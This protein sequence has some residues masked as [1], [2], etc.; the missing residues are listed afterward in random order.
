MTSH[1]D[2]PTL[3]YGDMPRIG[4]SVGGTAGSPGALLG[5]RSE[6]PQ[7]GCAV[8]PSCRDAVRGPRRY[9]QTRTDNFR[10]YGGAVVVNRVWLLTPTEFEEEVGAVVRPDP[11][12]PCPAGLHRIAAARDAALLDGKH[13]VL[14]WDLFTHELSARAKRVGQEG[15]TA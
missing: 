9:I 12:G 13:R 10:P 3:R 7:D 8:E 11:E 15:G 5:A 2:R 1:S 6:L 14:V 4:S